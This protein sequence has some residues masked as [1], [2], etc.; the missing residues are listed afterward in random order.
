MTKFLDGY[1]KA[2]DCFFKIL[3]ND[4][5]KFATVDASENEHSMKIEYG[6]FGE[7]D[8]EVQKRSGEKTYNVKL[9]TGFMDKEE[10][11][12]KEEEKGEDSDL[13][14]FEFENLGVIFDEGRKCSMKGFAGISGLEKITKEE[15]DKIMN[16]FDP[17]EAPPGP[18]KLQPNKEGKIIWFSGAPGMGKSTSAQF[19]AR[20]QGYVYYEADCF[21]GLKNPYVSLDVDNPTMA[22]MHQKPLKGQGMEER[23]DTMKKMQGSWGN[24]MQG[25]DYDKEALL[26]FYRL[27]AADIGREKKR[28]G[29]D[30]AV[31]TVIFTADMREALREVLGPDLIIVVLTMASADRRER[32]LARHKGDAKAA[33]VLDMFEKLMEGVQENEPNTIELKVDS[34]MTRDEVVDKVIKEVE[35]FS[36]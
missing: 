11:I 23:K 8:A 15:F 34:T 33:D 6:D 32:I 5:G 16:D 25:K 9:T 35:K 1:Y 17:I 4:N 10:N 22:A 3:K 7:A 19:L 26:D 30:F 13:K 27:L 21:G 36:C 18:Y 14:M 20:N 12:N 29:G 31:A 24:I 2:S 28:I